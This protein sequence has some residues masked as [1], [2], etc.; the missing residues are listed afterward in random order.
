MPWGYVDI[1]YT[2]AADQYNYDA[3]DDVTIT[4]SDN[5]YMPGTFPFYV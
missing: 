2:A 1:C 5:F 4:I 3:Y